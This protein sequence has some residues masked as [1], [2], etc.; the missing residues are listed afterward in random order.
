MKRGQRL[1]Y[2]LWAAIFLCSC[3]TKED[4]TPDLTDKYPENQWIDETMRRYYLW[5]D[6][7]PQKEKLDFSKEAETFFFSLL[8]GK[9][10]KTRNNSHYYYSSINKKSESVTKAFQGKSYS[11]GF[12]FQYYL[13]NDLKK[14]ALLVL[15]VLPGSP[16][17]NEGI[18]RGDW[19]MEID[20]EPVPGS[21]ESLLK[22]L[23]TTSPRTIT[24]GIASSPGQAVTS[25]KNVTAAMV[26]DNPV[27]LHKTIEHG[28]RRIAYMVYNHFTSGPTDEDGD[29]LFNNTMRD[30]FRQFKADNPD[31]F[32]LDLRYNGG[33][34]VS[35]AQLLATML[36]PAAAL[37]DVFC[38]LTY[39]GQNNSYSNRTLKLDS[40]YM[41]QGTGGDNLDLKR[42]YV[43]T[44]GRT[45]SASEAVING[46]R[47][48]IDVILV[49][50]Q[51]EGKNVGSVTFDNDRFD[52]ELHPIV[53]RLSNKDNFADYEDGFAPDMFC[54]ESKAK[55]YYELGDK[56]EFMLAAVLEHITGQTAKASS[57]SS[58]KVTLVP[59][60]NSLD[61]K[62]T[63]GVEL[64][65]E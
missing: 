64:G 20:G 25:R 60:Y 54:D 7:I 11:F 46:L 4:P 1:G 50:E 43:I 31:E 52:W 62:K 53:S 18:K 17:Q 42:L 14:Y 34:L 57:R 37:D 5:E 16:A 23:D 9:D 3:T 32:I 30:V 24:L 19:I 38:H 2:I 36:A 41:K 63:N 8:T 56:Q 22:A 27:F 51:T 28:G 29:E 33:G 15:Y 49:G 65:H 55:T 21:S 59:L 58:D 13:I 47:A 61:R 44:S 10:G 45:A 35:C 12:E 48:Y 40:K 6:E 26:E 39:N